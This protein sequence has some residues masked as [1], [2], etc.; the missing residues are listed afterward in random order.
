MDLQGVVMITKLKGI[1]E[2]NS[3]E[4]VIIEIKKDFSPVEISYIKIKKITK[5]TF[6]KDEWEYT[7]E[8]E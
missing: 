6:Q 5:E 2:G 8:F 7:I 3:I 1:V 4:N